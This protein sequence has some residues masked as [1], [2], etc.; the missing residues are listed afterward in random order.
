M[1]KTKLEYFSA[2]VKLT[3]NFKL[4]ENETGNVKYSQS[5]KDD[6]VHHYYEYFACT[7]A[8]ENKLYW[9]Q[10]VSEYIEFN[11]LERD[12]VVS[13]LISEI[14]HVYDGSVSIDSDMWF[15]INVTNHKDL[16][17]NMQCDDVIFG[18]IAIVE[19][20]RKVKP[21]E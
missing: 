6:T 11:E 2:M 21:D 17:I 12:D 15:G 13:C 14:N 18:L 7:C 8:D 5:T 10:K 9:Q 16:H 1:P 20:L 3:E 19:I 4:R